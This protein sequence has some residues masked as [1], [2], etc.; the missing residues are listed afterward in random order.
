MTGDLD[1]SKRQLVQTGLTM[2]GGLVAATGGLILAANAEGAKPGARAADEITP[3]EDLMREHGVLDRVMLVYEAGIN[4]FAAN[5]DFDPYVL[6]D[7][8][9][10]VKEFIEDYHER[11]EEKELFPRFRRANK[12][13]PLIDVLFRQHE[14]GRMLTRTIMQTA[15]GSRK[16][17]DDRH[18][19]TVAMAAFIRM[20]RPHAAR[21]DTELFPRLRG[22]VSANEFDAIAEQFEHDERDRFGEDGFEK[23]VDR[24]A[25]LERMIGINDLNQFTPPS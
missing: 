8:A 6:L 14:A 2:V 20:Y 23:M 11:A 18:K 16:D 15:P 5:E 22:L 21:E 9:Q 1:L 4:K 24:V 10:V 25:R 13:V 17:G 3:P 7:G 12:L 19:L